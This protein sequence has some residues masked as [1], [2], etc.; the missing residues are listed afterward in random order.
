MNDYIVN[1]IVYFWNNIGNKKLTPK[2]F[3]PFI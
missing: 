2:K 3:I 1:K